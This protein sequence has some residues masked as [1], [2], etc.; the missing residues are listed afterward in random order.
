MINWKE[1]DLGKLPIIFE[2]PLF[3]QYSDTMMS[4]DANNHGIR[5]VFFDTD[6]GVFAPTLS[7]NV[8]LLVIR[9]IED[10]RF[11]CDARL[12]SFNEAD[13]VAGCQYQMSDGV[14]CSYV[15]THR[16]VLMV[17]RD[18][19]SLF[20]TFSPLRLCGNGATL[21]FWGSFPSF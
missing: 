21:V 3:R 4:A 16:L 19:F 14:I 6:Q 5:A 10:Q 12:L 17:D 9:R 13:P 20:F 8:S 1:G 11:S 18:P 15:V 7:G 2:T